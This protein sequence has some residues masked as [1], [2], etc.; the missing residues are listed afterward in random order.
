[1]SKT[2]RDVIGLLLEVLQA[3]SG[4]HVMNMLHHNH[5]QL[6]R[7]HHHIHHPECTSLTDTCTEIEKDGLNL[8]RHQLVQMF[9]AQSWVSYCFLLVREP[10]RGHVYSSL[11]LQ[12]PFQ[13][14]LN[15]SMF[16]FKVSSVLCLGI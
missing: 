3:V 11:A 16:V 15:D 10:Q 14:L 7:F 4:S 9:F 1:M 5:Q 6:R 13:V 12:I 2:F 8:I